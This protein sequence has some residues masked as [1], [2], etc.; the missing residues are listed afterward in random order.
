MPFFFRAPAHVT[1]SLHIST[2]RGV[3][4]QSWRHTFSSE[5]DW[6]LEA[7]LVC[8]FVTCWLWSGFDVDFVFV[9]L[10]FVILSFH[11]VFLH[12]VPSFFLSFP[13]WCIGTLTKLR[14]NFMKRKRRKSFFS[15]SVITCYNL[16]AERKFVIF[17]FRDLDIISLSCDAKG[18]FSNLS[19]HCEQLAFSQ[20]IQTYKQSSF[21]RWAF[22][23]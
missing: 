19:F 13:F 2:V 8:L 5:L 4:F 22:S 16:S 11:S 23:D 18:D 12:F 15:L 21:S 7:V 20:G 6:C 14:Q 10:P 1:F 9:F 3:W 17:S